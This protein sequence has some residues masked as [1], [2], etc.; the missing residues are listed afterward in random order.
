MPDYRNHPTQILMQASLSGPGGVTLAGFLRNSTGVSF[1]KMRV[2]GRYAIV[3]LL[4][5]GGSYADARGRS[6]TVTAGDLIVIYP[7]LAHAYGP[8]PGGKWNEIYAIFDG[9]AVDAWRGE[10][11]AVGPVIGGL[12][13]IEFWTEKV[14]DV[15]R[16]PTPLEQLGRM[17]LL[18]AEFVEAARGRSSNHVDWLPKART[19]LSTDPHL[20]TADPKRVAA[21]LGVEYELFRKRFRS[22]VGM[23]P[24]RFR[25]AAVIEQAV[26][27]LRDP[28]HRLRD[29]AEQLG[30]C[31]EF[32]LSRR[33]RR[34]VGVSPTEFRQR[35]K[36]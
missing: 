24:G 3:Y 30:F 22:A 31:D 23:A 27:L 7:D 19:M 36:T 16:R 5:G 15:V 28:Q 6:R 14:L 29:I 20:P 2:L 1:E 10:L 26:A 33:F 35:L 8:R 18:L 9:P 13:P 4:A 17:T 11:D 12:E 25:D 32:H 34:F 21:A